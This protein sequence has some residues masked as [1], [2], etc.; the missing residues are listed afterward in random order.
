MLAGVIV[1]YDALNCEYTDMCNDKSLP[2]YLRHAANRARVVLNK[3]Y[4]KTD[5]SDLYRVAMRT[6]LLA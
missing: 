6:Y 3:Y 2:L 1:H 5:E 4:Q